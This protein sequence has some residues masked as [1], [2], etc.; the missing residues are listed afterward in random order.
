MCLISHIRSWC[1]A[2]SICLPFM[3]WFILRIL[4]VRNTDFRFCLNPKSNYRELRTHNPNRLCQCI[5]HKLFF[6]TSFLWKIFSFFLVVVVRLT[7]ARAH[8]AL[9]SLPFRW[10]T[11]DFAVLSLES[12]INVLLSHRTALYLSWKIFCAHLILFAHTNNNR[13]KNHEWW[14]CVFRGTAKGGENW[15][16]NIKMNMKYSVRHTWQTHRLL[17]TWLAPTE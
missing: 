7:L 16:C 4:L 1:L 11:N 8:G 5:L 14:M 15:W 6:C 17:I 2:T 3:Y 13:S 12:W 10:L 9:A